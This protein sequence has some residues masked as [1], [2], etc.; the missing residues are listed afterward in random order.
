[1]GGGVAVP[2]GTAG[3]SGTAPAR[4]MGTAFQPIYHVQGCVL[5]AYEALARPVNEAGAAVA[6]SDY[7]QGFAPAELP[8]IDRECRR[9]HLAR[10]ARLGAAVGDLHLNMHPRA[11][12]ADA[13]AVADLVEELKL[14]ALAPS[15]LCIEILQDE[16]GDEGRLVEAAAGYRDFGVKV[17]MDDFGAVR[18][19]FDR[20][21][22]L[23]PDYVKVD[24]GRLERA[25]GHDMAWRML[26]GIIGLLHDAGT[27]VVVKGL[28]EASGAL[29][30]IE[31]GADYVQGRYFGAVRAGLPVDQLAAPLLAELKKL[32]G[33]PRRA[34]A[35]AMRGPA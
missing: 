26:P 7:F 31:A 10:F 35:L 23:A 21:A 4:R 28:E 14:H 18:S 11:A 34:A 3:M 1:M 22:T 12:L 33:M 8:R 15:R 27:R 2:A 30:A 25:V 29:H 13:G 32:G 19:N 17:A 5:S 9:V 20:L 24:G 6:P 16:S